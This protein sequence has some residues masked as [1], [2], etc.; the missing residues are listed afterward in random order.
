MPPLTGVAV[1]VTVVPWHTG[2][3]S[4][5]IDTAGVTLAVVTCIT[6]L[7]AVV[8]FA[9]GSVLV[10]TT[11]TWSLLFNVVVVKVTPVCPATGLPLT[12]HWYV[13]FAPPF[14]GVAVNVMLCPEQI[15]LVG[16]VMLTVGVTVVIVIVTWLLVAV[17]VVTQFALL[18]MITVTTSPLASALLEKVGLLV[19]TFAPFTCH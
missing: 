14:V 13:G 8:G 3:W 10:I 18:V 2:F 5:T 6:L 7:V 16:E 19:P 9:H 1:N 15:E 12:I 17:G 11:V 4:A